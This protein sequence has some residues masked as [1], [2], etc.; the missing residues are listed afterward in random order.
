MKSGK[1]E[2]TKIPINVTTLRVVWIEISMSEE[3]N[4]EEEVTTL[5][6]VWIEILYNVFQVRNLPVTTLRVV[7]IEILASD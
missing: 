3:M 1:E 4:P 6:V 7:W 2:P 5:R